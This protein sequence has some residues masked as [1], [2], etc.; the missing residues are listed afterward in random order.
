MRFT[1]K[2]VL[3]LTAGATLL[4]A[5]GCTTASID[6]S[7][8]SGQPAAAASK[9]AVSVNEQ[10]RALLPAAVR[11]KGTLV[12][13]SDPTYPPFEYFDTDNK[14]M[15]GWDVDMGDALAQ[16][17]G[18]KAEHVAATFDTILPGLT[19]QKYDAGMSAFSITEER[20]K[21]VDFV[22]YMDG[23]S[24]IAVAPGNPQQLSM[25]AET[26][27][28]KKVAAQ[29]GSSQSLDV[30]P[31]LSKECTDA[32]KPAIDA[33]L[34]PAQTDANLA[35]TSG[36]V[37]GVMADSVSLAYQGTL[38][39]KKFELAA[40][41]DYQPE[42]VGV[43]LPKDSALRP[44]IEAAMKAIVGSPAYGEINAKWSIPASTTITVD[45]V[46]AK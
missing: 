40:G 44:A 20:K 9:T 12:I 2:A 27:C 25:K 32:G 21:A 33:Q 30:M 39:G 14:T 5:S 45:K 15:I 34:F 10:A 37:D 28:G 7:A 26:L 41:E 13:G 43:A 35:L 46:T 18:L 1:H 23:G 16:T 24:G 36:R 3:L 29:K 19:S 11:D 38:A 6:E 22:P 42:P 4:A 31:A 17:L 8:A